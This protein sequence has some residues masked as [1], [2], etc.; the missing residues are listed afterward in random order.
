MNKGN[1]LL[2]ANL[3]L[4]LEMQKLIEVLK[5]LGVVDK[6]VVKKRP[7][8]NIKK[9]MSSTKAIGIGKKKKELYAK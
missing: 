9:E 6:A 5:E 7:V 2:E 3:S 1:W 8:L 4:I